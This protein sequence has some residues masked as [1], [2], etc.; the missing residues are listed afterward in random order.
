MF[1]QSSRPAT[2]A[3]SL[4]RSGNSYNLVRLIAA[5]LVIVSHATALRFGLV[6]EI[7]EASTP[8]SLAG[9][10]VNLFFVL[11]GV[12]VSASFVRAPSLARFAVARILRVFPAAIVC[13]ILL[14]FGLGAVVTTEQPAAY[15]AARDVWLYPLWGGVL[16]DPEATLPGVFDTVPL[17]GQLNDPLW[18]LGYELACYGAV[19]LLGV[20]GLLQ[21]RWITLLLALGFILAQLGVDVTLERPEDPELLDIVLRFGALFSI[22]VCAFAWRDTLRLRLWTIPPVLA[23]AWFTSD[24]D[25][26]TTIWFATTAWTALMLGALPA[27]R[28]RAAANRTDLSYGIY[29]YGW[30][31]GQAIV[32]LAPDISVPA[33]IAAN[34]VLAGSAAWLSWHLIEEPV[35]ARKDDVARRLFPPLRRS[36]APEE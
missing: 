25:A 7:L 4:T 19:A 27:G 5:A 28:W 1:Q 8:F 13:A 17:E 15:F 11:S 23:A 22:G 2:L 24:S 21:N 34:L 3:H 36:A 30:P 16:L 20:A 12:M 29:I 26:A 10:A 31:L 18:T 33:L 6:D 9:H 35:L 14:A 32:A